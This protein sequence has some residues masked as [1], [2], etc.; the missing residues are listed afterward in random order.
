MLNMST[1]TGPLT[2]MFKISSRVYRLKHKSEE[3]WNTWTSQRQ[4]RDHQSSWP[5]STEFFYS[6]IQIFW[7]KHQSPFPGLVIAESH[8]E[9]LCQ[10]HENQYQHRYNRHQKAPMPR[11]S[12]HH[13]LQSPWH[14]HL[15]T[16][17]TWM[18][19][20]TT[21]KRNKICSSCH[22]LPNKKHS[23]SNVVFSLRFLTH[24][25]KLTL[26]ISCSAFQN[27]PFEIQYSIS[28][29]QYIDDIT[30][31]MKIQLQ[32][33]LIHENLCSRKIPAII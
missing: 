23:T 1:Y 29:I 15:R 12:Q 28:K 25:N 18:H 33:P 31:S 14:A 11:E 2:M 19:T 10:L 16:T 17:K 30:V 7:K 3:N 21:K 9:Y 24:S 8:K 26:N 4:A 13:R 32:S 6:L 20:K 27:D 5:A 22:V